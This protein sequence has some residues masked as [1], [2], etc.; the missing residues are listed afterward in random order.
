MPY[1]LVRG[2]TNKWPDNYFEDSTTHIYVDKA[3]SEKLVEDLEEWKGEASC[4]Q[5]GTKIYQAVHY[6]FSTQQPPT[7]ALNILQTYGYKVIAANH[8]QGG[9]MWTL[10]GGQPR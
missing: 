6:T 8:V 10:E 7:T 1:V 3:G 5:A 2:D 9:C 4:L